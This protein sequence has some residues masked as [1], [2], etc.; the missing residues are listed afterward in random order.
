MR[1]TD[2]DYA[3]AHDALE[4]ATD[5]VAVE[6]SAFDPSFWFKST[7]NVTKSYKELLERWDADKGEW[8]T[9]GI[10]MF[11]QY[12]ADCETIAGPF[13]TN[14]DLG[15]RWADFKYRLQAV[16]QNPNPGLTDVLGADVSELAD[17]A[18]DWVESKLPS[19]ASFGSVGKYLL[20]ALVAVGVVLVLYAI[21]PAL[22]AG[23]SVYSTRKSAA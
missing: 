7:D 4:A 3:I 21:G 23:A 12:L 14:Y 11:N 20:W 18:R 17:N 10:R 15:V 5:G 16:G 1:V 22:Q 6:H 8:T 2:K 19:A 9:G 13:W